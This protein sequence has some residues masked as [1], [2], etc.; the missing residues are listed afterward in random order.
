MF[1]YHKA[2]I[3]GMITRYLYRPSKTNCRAAM[4]S[5][6]MGSCSFTTGRR[7]YLCTGINKEYDRNKPYNLSYYFFHNDGVSHSQWSMVNAE[8]IH[9]PFGAN[10]LN[11]VVKTGAYKRAGKAA[12]RIING[13]LATDNGTGNKQWAKTRTKKQITRFKRTRYKSQGI[14]DKNQETSN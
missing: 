5:S 13:Q 11:T 3:A 9:T 1:I 10:N 12:V 7:P 8:I 4:N 2:A 14:R 6:T